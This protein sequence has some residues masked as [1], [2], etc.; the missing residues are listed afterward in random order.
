MNLAT[1]YL[2]LD[3]RNPLVASAG[4]MTQ[5]ADRVKRLAEAGVG[6]VVLPSLFEEQI[7]AEADRDQR[8]A[9]VGSD[10]FG[11]ATSYLPDPGVSLWPQQ[12]LSLIERAVGA[13][14]VPV[15]ASLNGSTAG[16]WTD[17]ARAMQ[18]AG[19]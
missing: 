10:S 11:E 4:P 16:G 12:Y 18:G 14:A 17:Y 5:T 8:L 13:A 19:A 9:E 3:L 7:R 15:I 1:R 2:G 6:A